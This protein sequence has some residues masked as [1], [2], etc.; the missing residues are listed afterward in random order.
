M[1][2][3]GKLFLA[4]CTSVGSVHISLPLKALLD[5][6]LKN[7]IIII[8]III[9][10]EK[11]HKQH[12]SVVTEDAAIAKLSACKSYQIE[13]RGPKFPNV[14][15]SAQNL[16]PSQ[17]RP[18][19]ASVRSY[20]LN[21][22]EHLEVRCQVGTNCGSVQGIDP[23][24]WSNP[25]FIME[26]QRERPTFQ[27]MNDLETAPVYSMWKVHVCVCLCVKASRKRKQRQRGIGGG[28]YLRNCRNS[29]RNLDNQQQKICRHRNFQDQM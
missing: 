4:C 7:S 23:G 17:M 10:L 9:V 12:N 19:Q 8:I 5:S 29:T 16:P 18:L 22:W 26:K 24:S 20:M 3:K 1:G 15:F 28:D 6:P 27:R 11:Q 13:D 2:N 21:V 25:S 14:W